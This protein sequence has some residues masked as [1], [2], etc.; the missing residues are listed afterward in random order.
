MMD[1]SLLRDPVFVAVCISSLMGFAALYV[2]FVY[3]VDMAKKKVS[4]SLTKDMIFQ[5]LCSS[6]DRLRPSLAK[7]NVFLWTAIHSD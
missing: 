3:V 1:F 5:L 6:W 2:P 4:T 7:S